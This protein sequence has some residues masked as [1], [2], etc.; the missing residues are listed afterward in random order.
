MG[1]AR[2]RAPGLGPGIER[3]KSRFGTVPARAAVAAGV[4]SIL[5]SPAHAIPS[6]DL[7]VN[8]FSSVAQLIGL[9]TVVG[10]V[11]AVGRRRMPGASAAIN[12]GGKGWRWV[13]MGAGVLLLGSLA[14]NVLQYVSHVDDTNRRLQANLVRPSTEAG[15]KVGD[16]NLKTL[17]YSDQL[18]NPAGISTDEF[19]AILESAR[20]G[21]D[22]NLIDLREPEEQ[23]VGALPQLRR[24]R[25][26]DLIDQIAALGLRDRMNIL[27]C[28]SGN[29]SSESCAKLAELGIPCKFV[30]GGFEKWR[31]ENRPVVSEAGGEMVGLRDVPDFPNKEVLLDTPEVARLLEEENALF[32]DVRYPQEFEAWHLPGAVNVPLRRMKTDEMWASLK[33]LPKRPIIAACYDKRSC[34]FSLVLGVRLT[35]LGY[36]FRGRYTV[37]FEYFEPPADQPYVMRWKAEQEQSVMGAAA[38]TLRVMTG[39][40]ADAVGSLPLAILAMVVLLRL[41]VL[42]FTVKAERD[43]EVLRRL[44]EEIAGLKERLKDDKTRLGRATQ[45]LYRKHRLTPGRNLIGVCIQ[46]PLF[47]LFFIAVDAISAERG[48]T[49]GWIPDLGEP[50]PHYVLPAVLG[51]LIFLHLHLTGSRRDLKMTALRLA[52]GVGL[53]YITLYLAAG[54]NL[55]LVLSVALMMVQAQV[56]RGLVARRDKEPEVAARP[57]PVHSPVRVVPLAEADRVAGVG[58]KALRL[59]Q[60]MRAGLPVPQGLVITDFAFAGAADGYSLTQSDSREVHGLW[61]RLGIERAAVR[62]SGAAEDGAERS[63][64]GVYESILGV[65]RDDLSNAV[66]AVRESMR[67]ARAAAY[68]GGAQSG[69]GVI[70]QQVVEA[71]HAGVLFTEHP[72]EAGTILV[73]MTTGLGT[74]A[75]TDG[76]AVPDAFRFGRLTGRPLDENRPP[77]DL[78][79]LLEM[80]RRAEQLFGAPQDIEWTYRDGRFYLLQSRNVTAAVRLSPNGGAAGAIERDRHRLLPAAEG[81][82]PDEVVFVQDELAELLPRPTPFSLSFMESLWRPGGSVDLACRYLGIP[83]DVQ[84]DSPPLVTTVFGALYVNAREKARRF[85]RGP[86]VLASFRLAREAERIEAQFREDFL[87]AY[88]E[89]IGLEE[90]IDLHRLETSELFRLYR[91]LRDRFVKQDYVQAEIINL[92]AGFYLKQAEQGLSRRGLSVVDHL[93]NIPPTVVH[94]AM[95]LLPEIR[96]GRRPVSDFLKQFGHRAPVDYELADPRYAESPELVGQLVESARDTHLHA[97]RPA[98]RQPLD[99]EPALRL[100]VERARRFQALKEEAKHHCLRELALI[101]RVLL[102]LDKRLQLGGGIFYLTCDEI[103]AADRQAADHLGSIAAR[104]ADAAAF[105]TVGRLPTEITAADLETLGLP[106]RRKAG[107]KEGELHGTLVAGTAPVEGRAR[108]VTNGEAVSA[109]RGEILVARHIHPDWIPLFPD[110]AGMVVELGGWLSHGALIAREYDLTTVVGVRGATEQIADGDLVRIEPDGRVQ[111]L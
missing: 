85:R 48:G 14:G 78:K 87:P 38:K 94:Q 25:F 49:F 2:K 16:V 51:L 42:P 62:S 98:S 71:E 6:P 74:A 23:E 109:V 104:R 11:F 18:V 88:L 56:V 81:A 69:G 13:A 36:D 19:A 83:Y 15:K 9:A 82:G 32:V 89:A 93:A 33:A 97:S 58:N 26:P 96:A 27:F 95:S 108:V 34:F 47:I 57:D 1:V 44:S 40:I 66:R 77:I 59:A 90:A 53:G 80:G 45:A 111:R 21:T 100:V 65:R 106:G 102:E 61:Q 103:D 4:L 22:Y 79:P 68:G 24:V 39:A 75:V 3:R 12:G 50:D 107:E 99:K 67:R 43:Q 101:R 41:I 55:Y 7:A 54:V 76:S 30:Q 31:A 60:M 92:A 52:A 10:G 84:E 70:V 105:E 72:A 46:V 110:L 17:S 37:P 86:G 20:D 35:R 91:R 73:E 5:S 64:A 29:R 63:F 28:E 8:L